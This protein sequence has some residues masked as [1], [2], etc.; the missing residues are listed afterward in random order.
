MSDF[1][2]DLEKRDRLILR[3]VH[4]PGYLCNNEIEV[5]FWAYAKE[6]DTNWITITLHDPDKNAHVLINSCEILKA[7]NHLTNELVFEHDNRTN[8]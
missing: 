2:S 6:G 8:L 4:R 3:A 7:Y 1:P 5:Y